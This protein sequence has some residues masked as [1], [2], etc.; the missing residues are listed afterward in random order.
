MASPANNHLEL[1]RA[2]A[3][4]IGGHLPAD[5]EPPAVA[6]TGVPCLLIPLGATEQ[7]GPHLPLATD[8]II[9]SAWARAAAARVPRTMV[10]PALPYGSS[11]EHQG[12]AGT[13]SIGRQ[14]LAAVITEL[15][16]SV[17]GY[18]QRTV[19]VCGHGGNAPV[20]GPLVEQ[21][22]REGHSVSWLTPRWPPDLAVDAHG[23]KTET[24]LLLHL[25]PELVRPHGEVTGTT[26]P[27]AELLPELQLRGLAAV[28]ANGVLGDPS[29][30]SAEHGAEL[31]SHLVTTLVDELTAMEPPGS[32]GS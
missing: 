20:L 17:A 12:F 2:T 1:G 7:H 27:L 32:A 24:S 19:L 22:N 6:P 26:T 5:N 13:M 16:R 11:G 4:E 15:I 25:A 30:A 29:Q 23:G 31:F 9:A 10:A 18:C 21:L 8:T 28:T 14:A 3:E